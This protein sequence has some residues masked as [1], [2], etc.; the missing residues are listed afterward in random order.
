M[1]TPKEVTQEMLEAA[2]KKAVETGLLPKLVDEDT[3]LKN[4]S[5][6]KAVLQAALD[7]ADQ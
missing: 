2:M 6:M 4:W 3:Y 5:G 7:L 1:P